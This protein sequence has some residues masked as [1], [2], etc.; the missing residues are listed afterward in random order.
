MNPNSRAN[1][2]KGNPS[3]NRKATGRV[4]EAQTWRALIDAVGELPITDEGGLA[5]LHGMGIDKKWLAARG[6]AY[7][8]RKLLKVL[9]M[10]ADNSPQM[11]R[12]LLQRSEPQAQEV[13]LNLQKGYAIISPDDWDAE[14]TGGA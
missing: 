1:L 9:L 12:E 2:R 6:M 14:N 5:K 8:T 10:Y 11:V 3:G 4:P 13:N 7:P